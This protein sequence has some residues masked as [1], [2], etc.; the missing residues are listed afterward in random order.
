MR[1]D[2]PQALL[3][4]FTAKLKGRGAR[5]MIGLQRVFKMMDDDESGSLSLRE[6]G[7][8]CKD[9]R[10][11]IS[12][13][14]VPALF[15]MFDANGDG[16]LAYDEFLQA[17]RGEL[18]PR[19]LVVVRKAF[20]KIDASGNG[21]L[22]LDEVKAA[23]VSTKHPDVIQGK[24]SG[25][26]VLCEFLETFEAH[27]NMMNGGVREAPITIE[28]FTD[29]Y[30]SVSA[31]ID[32][33]DQFVLVMNNLWGLKG[34]SA[35]AAKTGKGWAGE[36]A[37]GAAAMKAP[38]RVEDEDYRNPT[39]KPQNVLRSGMGS[40]DNP[41]NHTTA[42]YPP[43]NSAS[44]GSLSNAMYQSPAATTKGLAPTDEVPKAAHAQ[45]RSKP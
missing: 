43:V 19:R 10:I 22:E 29:Y 14:N 31:S 21:V 13:E 8:A 39:Y 5:G 35:A 3:L 32:S 36:D 12:E 25:E 44:R 26:N 4:L 40:N 9:F 37:K 30:T 42:Y 15:S 18:N 7:K 27:H 1:Q 2:S 28:E 11:G 34:G 33:D 6:F 24:R 20:S 45:Y 16:T 23:Y 17:V 38:Q 41:L